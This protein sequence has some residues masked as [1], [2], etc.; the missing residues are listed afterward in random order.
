MAADSAVKKSG[1]MQIACI[2]LGI[3]GLFAYGVS[4]FSSSRIVAILAIAGLLSFLTTLVALAIRQRS[5]WPIAKASA[6]TLLA[7]LLGTYLILVPLVYFFQDAIANGT[8]AFFQPHGISEEEALALASDDVE[9]I[10]LKTPDGARLAGWLVQNSK[11]ARSPL[12]IFFDGSGS[13]TWKAVPYARKL[14]GWSVALIN[15]RGFAPSTGTPSHARALADATF[16]YDTLAHRPDINPNHIAAMGYSL[17]TGIAVY[18]AEQRPLAGTILVAPYDNQTLIGLKHTPLFAPLAGIMH[19][20]FDSLSRAPSIRSPLLCLIGAEDPVVPPALSLKVAEGWGGE[21]MVQIY[22]GE[23]HG[24]L[25]H[26]N[27]SWEDIAAFL[28][29]VNPS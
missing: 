24:L 12:L 18:L 5:F 7:V 17:G 9:V 8:N 14:A 4:K 27:S 3:F 26:Q 22:E 2:L 1:K 16:I 19:R 28:K 10:D 21:K 29:K 25:A 15:Y 23:D 11:E 6:V 20:Y 13:E